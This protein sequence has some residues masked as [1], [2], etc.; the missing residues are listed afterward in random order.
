ME[1]LALT[2]NPK[3]TYS[4]TG[5]EF[6]S[7]LTYGEWAAMGMQLAPMAKAIGFLVGDWINYGVTRYGEKYV[8]ATRAT[9]LS[10]E[11]LTMYSLVARRVEIRT[12][13][14]N[15]DFTHHRVVAKL[16]DP[17]DQKKWLTLADEDRMSVARLRKS[18]NAGRPITREEHKAEAEDTTDRGYVTY[19]ASLNEIR[20]WWIRETDKLPVEKWDADRRAGLKEHFK[21][22]V[23]IYEQL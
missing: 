2:N 4:A 17:E 1:T 20:R 18:I 9:G 8:E 3:F 7:D 6:H 19:L 16:K 14:R 12:R 22:V 10:V 15:L 23:V 5:I 13:V 11:T 21:F